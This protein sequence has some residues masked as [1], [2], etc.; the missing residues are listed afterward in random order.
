MSKIIII[1]KMYEYFLPLA[2]YSQLKYFHLV[3]YAAEND[4]EFRLK[5]YW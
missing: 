4:K 2:L 5:V 3:R 1:D